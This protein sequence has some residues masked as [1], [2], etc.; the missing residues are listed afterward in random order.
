MFIYQ[1]NKE[2]IKQKAFTEDGLN[3]TEYISHIRR[4]LDQ[5]IFDDKGSKKYLASFITSEHIYNKVKSES[6]I[7]YFPCRDII[8]PCSIKI[9]REA[10][11]EQMVLEDIRSSLIGLIKETMTDK[12]LKPNQLS[13]YIDLFRLYALKKPVLADSAVKADVNLFLNAREEYKSH[14][15]E[16]K[17]DITRDEFSVYCLLG[18]YSIC[19]GASDEESNDYAK[20]LF[21]VYQ[22][23]SFG[24]I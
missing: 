18:I 21:S 5:F 4:V 11:S 16:D 23:Y 15:E 22:S 24:Y 14:F 20:D 9:I 8:S 19:A 7:I 10:Q 2:G 13:F 12:T 3:Y 17:K 6:V 1:I